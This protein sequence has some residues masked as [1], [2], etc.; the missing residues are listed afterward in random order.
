[1]SNDKDL[2][3][4]EYREFS[5]TQTEPV[6]TK[7]LV[8]LKKL[9]FPSPWMVFLKLLALHS[10][11]GFFSL[12]I[13]HQFGLNPFQTEQSLMDWFMRFGGH[14]FCMVA[15]GVVFMITT[16][17]IA[18]QTLSL[19]ELEAIRRHK[20]LQTSLLG[21]LSLSAFYFFG[22]ELLLV[23]A[24]LWLFGGLLGSILALET[25]YHFRKTRFNFI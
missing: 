3:L 14:H 7:T 9:L 25:T 6:P 17:L 4:K 10:I 1:M 20:W 5:N 23:F 12:A 15:C 21:I 19:S 8:Q 11:S 22:A 2:W 18:G 13:C 16:Y 24:L